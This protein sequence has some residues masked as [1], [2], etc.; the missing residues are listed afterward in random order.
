MREFPR[1]PLLGSWVNKW[2]ALKDQTLENALYRGHTFGRAP[3]PSGG[4]A[5]SYFGVPIIL[6]PVDVVILA[7]Q[8]PSGIDKSDPRNGSLLKDEGGLLHDEAHD[9][10][11]SANRDDAD[12]Q[13][14][15]GVSLA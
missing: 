4:C 11:S 2:E 6:L 15:T 10:G 1:T 9:F 5:Y 13:R 3:H 8:Y 12:R 14:L 7:S